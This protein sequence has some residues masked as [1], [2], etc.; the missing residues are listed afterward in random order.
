MIAGALL[1]IYGISG[2]VDTFILKSKI[3]TV[4][5]NVKKA[6]KTAKTL[7][8]DVKEAEVVEDK[9]DKKDEEKDDKKS[10]KNSSKK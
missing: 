3:D 1:I 5:E 9:D 2:L 4:K 6:S 8:D 10:D 7:L